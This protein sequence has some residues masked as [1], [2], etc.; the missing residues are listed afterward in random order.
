MSTAVS[1]KPIK[2]KY[3]FSTNN[4]VV[5]INKVTATPIIK[6]LDTSCKC[7][8]NILNYCLT[9]RDFLCDECKIDH[10]DHKSIKIDL[11]NSH[12]NIK[13]YSDDIKKSISENINALTESDLNFQKHKF[14]DL[15]SRREIIIRKL[16]E[17]EK[18]QERQLSALHMK[19]VWNMETCLEKMKKLKKKIE[20]TMIEINSDKNPKQTKLKS[21]IDEMFQNENEINKIS[22]IIEAYKESFELNKRLD[23]IYNTIDISLDNLKEQNEA[24]QVPLLQDLKNFSSNKRK[25]TALDKKIKT[26]RVIKLPINDNLS[27]KNEF[28]IPKTFHN[29]DT[30]SLVSTSKTPSNKNLNEI[31]LNKHMKTI[32][33]VSEKS[34]LTIVSNKHNKVILSKSSQFL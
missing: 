20:K 13:S 18:W 1:L 8:K 5:N 15:Q 32:S 4:S 19:T 24:L 9:C 12:D 26:N 11:N 27:T 33:L 17:I 6:N 30:Y 25:I 16:D 14:L 34:D 22:N 28:S 21:V 31:K 10:N 29:S 3:A 23:D 7:M 2:T